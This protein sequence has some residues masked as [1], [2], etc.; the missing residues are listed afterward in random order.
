LPFLPVT[1]LY[2][3]PLSTTSL[4]TFAAGKKNARNVVIRRSSSEEPAVVRAAEVQIRRKLGMTAFR[5]PGSAKP[6]DKFAV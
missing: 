2:E 5:S 4:T 6:V 3:Q 1:G